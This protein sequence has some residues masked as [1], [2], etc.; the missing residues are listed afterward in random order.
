[1]DVEFGALLGRSTSQASASGRPVAGGD[2]AGDAEMT[3]LGAAPASGRRVSMGVFGE[4]EE[5]SAADAECCEWMA[6]A[7]RILG[8]SF[9][10]RAS[11]RGNLVAMPYV[12]RRA[13]GIHKV[14]LL[15]VKPSGFSASTSMTAT[16]TRCR[17]ASST[18]K[19][20]SDQAGVE[21]LQAQLSSGFAKQ[22][23]RGSD[24]DDEDEER[25]PA[26][27]EV[28][29]AK[30][31][32]YLQSCLKGERLAADTYGRETFELALNFCRPLKQLPAAARVI[33]PGRTAP[34]SSTPASPSSAAK[35]KEVADENMLLRNLGAWLSAVTGRKVRT[36]LASRT[37]PIC[38]VSMGSK[39]S[40]TAKE[41][42]ED[43]LN[44]VYYYLTANNLRAALEELDSA[45]ARIPESSRPAF[46]RLATLIAACGGVSN[47]S[48]DRRQWLAQQL[49]TWQHQGAKSMMP[50]ALFRIFSLLAGD[51][52]E[53]VYDAL[54]WRGAL[55]IY[56]WY[57]CADHSE[58]GLSPK[59]RL[60]RSF[61]SFEKVVAAQGLSCTVRPNPPSGMSGLSTAAAAAR[62]ETSA[63]SR[64]AASS[65]HRSTAM[66]TSSEGTL[67]GLLDMQYSI[68]RASVDQFDW[69]NLDVLDYPSYTSEPFNMVYA[70]HL[71]LVLLA[72]KGGD[73]AMPGFQRLTQQYVLSLELAGAWQY[74]AFV[75]LFVAEPRARAR[76]VKGILARNVRA[77]SSENLKRLM[78]AQ[79]WRCPVSW[80]W[81]AQAAR[82]ESAKEWPLAISGWTENGRK[83]R[84]LVIALG[85]L[86][87]P[88]LAH[89][90][91]TPWALG[92][93]GA[94]ALP[95]TMPPAG[96]WL[97]GMLERILCDRI[98][99]T[100]TLTTVGQDAL[101]FL[102]SWE[103]DPHAP[104]NTADVTK[105]YWRC[106]ML[107]CYAL[108]LP[109]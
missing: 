26:N 106:D 16:T 73:I 109:W 69:R 5:P 95:A 31:T 90:A 17:S 83:E 88:L 62:Q 36:H 107:R 99:Y 52:D 29:R 23:P 28:N 93:G 20:E 6:K 77:T 8:S 59:Q 3:G 70:W 41:A 76:I 19:P 30:V 82:S 63:N 42:V 104:Y 67:G 66:D 7:P 18:A 50:P 102:R 12:D 75:A 53:V 49:Q 38:F 46:D 24:D 34:S 84:A 40:S 55:A 56:I 78:A 11:M 48:E 25:Y 15:R 94:L 71:T 80:W 72:L 54:D 65:S 39:G 10:F 105:L 74:A 43:C 58:A 4:V 13:G 101:Q 91:S 14:R 100:D 87:A 61:S 51:L 32:D 9:S 86:Q 64:A 98:G 33:S 35:P 81:D 2:E 97:R 89:Y 85:C 92:A 27:V 45:L 96:K 21:L 47:A 108:G 37:R 103:A 44:A 60:I 57:R 1:M 79:V 22:R 68:M